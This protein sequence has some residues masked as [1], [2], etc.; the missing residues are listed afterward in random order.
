MGERFSK[1]KQNRI[2][3]KLPVN[4]ATLRGLEEGDIVVDYKK[5]QK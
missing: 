2:L 1:R 4:P 5:Q 3:G